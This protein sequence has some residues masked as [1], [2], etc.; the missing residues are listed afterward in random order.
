MVV[1]TALLALLLSTAHLAFGQQSQKTLEILSHD[2]YDWQLFETNHFRIHYP[3]TSFAAKELPTIQRNLEDARTLALAHLGTLD[4]ERVVDVFLVDTRADVTKLMGH[5]ATGMANWYGHFVILVHNPVWEAF[6]RHEILHV[7]HE[8]VWGMGAEPFQWFQEGLATYSHG[9]CGPYEMEEITTYLHRQSMLYG[10]DEL[11]RSFGQLD[12]MIRNIQAASLVSYLYERYGMAKVR[13]LWVEG[14]DKIDS[15]L[16]ISSEELE[17][18]F[19]QHL[20]S[21]RDYGRTID[22]KILHD[23]GCS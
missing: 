6:I 1:S 8:N 12:E 14:V 4:Y 3:R 15:V 23:K 22:W 10:L 7:Y 2:D 19:F 11:F 9:L 17:A 5:G 16:G 20:E 18:Q 13:E 21:K